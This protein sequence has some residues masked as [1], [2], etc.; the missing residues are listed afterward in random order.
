[1]KIRM[2]QS[3]PSLAVSLCALSVAVAGAG[4]AAFNVAQNAGATGAT[5]GLPEVI[6]SGGES[7]MSAGETVVLGTDGHFTFHASCH[8]VGGENVVTFSVTANTPAD[9]DGNGPN[10][11]GTKIIIHTNSDA[12]DGKAPDTFDQVESASDSTEIA[13]DGEEADIFYN[14]G[15]NWNVRN[16]FAGFNGII[17]QKG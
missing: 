12:L 5:N 15:V 6:S 10:P 3:S 7:F 13:T 2:F 8:S 9:L 14:D 17:T 4:Y 16:C 1:M 11:A